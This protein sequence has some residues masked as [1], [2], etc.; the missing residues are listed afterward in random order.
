[1]AIVSILLIGTTPS[2]AQSP[3]PVVTEVKPAPE[4]VEAQLW[5]GNKTAQ[6]TPGN[7]I[8]LSGQGIVCARG[9]GKLAYAVKRGNVLVRGA[10]VVA[11]KGG[12]VE[13]NG[14]G[15][16]FQWGNWTIYW[17]KGQ[18]RVSG[19][20]YEVKGWVEN[21]YTRGVGAGRVTFRGY[22]RIRYGKLLLKKVEAEAIELPQE[23]IERLP[24][25]VQS[26]V[27]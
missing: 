14:W 2:L 15:G 7:P 4:A 22:W 23:V 17:G 24:Q 25:D 13:T 6:A 11:V 10:G 21:A 19:Q 26:Q 27:R 5:C 18:V 20:N 16:K 8:T 3:E 9:R 1:M 12:Q